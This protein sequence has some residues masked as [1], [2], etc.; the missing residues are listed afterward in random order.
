MKTRSAIRSDL[1]AAESSGPQTDSLDDL[2]VKIS[3]FV[4]FAALAGEV[5]RVTPQMVSAKG[6]H[7]P[8]PTKTMARILILKPLHNLSVG[9]VEFQVLDRLNF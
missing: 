6:G 7:P 3:G 1:F 8:F 2:L 4:D 5:F 9:Q